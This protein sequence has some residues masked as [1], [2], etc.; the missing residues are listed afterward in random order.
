MFKDS[1]M[2][3]DNIQNGL[4]ELGTAWELPILSNFLFQR[5]AP[6]QNRR[7]AIEIQVSICQPDKFQGWISGCRSTD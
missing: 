4:V 3:K 1:R 5:A 6:N 7:N 2:F